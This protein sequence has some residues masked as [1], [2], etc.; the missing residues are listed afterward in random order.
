MTSNKA[1]EDQEKSD[2]LDT[3]STHR[4]FLRHAV[5]DLTD[6][7]AGQRT[8]V[9]EL[10]LGGLIKHVTRAE[11]RWTGFIV[12]GPAAMDLSDEA[13]MKAHTDSFR[14][15]DGDTLAGLL[16]SYEEVARNT[17]DLVT[18][19]PSLDAS[20]PLPESPWFKPGA[21][22]TVRRVLLHILAETAQHAGHADIIRESLDGA[23]TMG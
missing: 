19:L 11:H 17:S 23:K 10:C 6:E 5:R 8:T 12:G 22:W 13:A 20:Q 14:M 15:Q 16:E 1:A 7:Q 2:F 18:A 9:S 4:S 3:L 21:R